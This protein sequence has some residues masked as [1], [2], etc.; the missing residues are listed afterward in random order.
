MT[1]GLDK[2]CVV[3]GVQ[4]KVE[5]S[6]GLVI[7]EVTHDKYELE[8]SSGSKK[9]VYSWFD[10]SAITLETD[11]L[12]KIAVKIPAGTEA[13]EYTITISEL[14]MADEKFDPINAIPE[15]LTATVKVGH[16]AAKAV[17]EGSLIATPTVLEP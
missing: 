17:V 14:E 5:V 3:G 11:Y 12:A 13:G 1:I 16:T 4:F 15:V 6:D 10:W 8:A 7:E 2:A 9:G